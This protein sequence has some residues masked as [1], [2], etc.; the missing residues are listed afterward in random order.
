MINAQKRAQ[1]KLV[2][3]FVEHNV[4]FLCM[5]DL[6]D[7]LKACLPDSTVNFIGSYMYITYVLYTIFKNKTKKFFFSFTYSR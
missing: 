5:G 2:A 4:P 3:V 6:V 7:S 1:V